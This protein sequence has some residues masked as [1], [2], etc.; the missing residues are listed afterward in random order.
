M[1]K[2]EQLIASLLKDAGEYPFAD[3]EKALIAFGCEKVRSKGSHHIFRHPTIKGLPSIPKKGGKNVKRYYVKE[4][5]KVL[6]LKEWYEQQ[7]K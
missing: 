4:I 1:S 5:V 2:L 6:E 7:K 3:V